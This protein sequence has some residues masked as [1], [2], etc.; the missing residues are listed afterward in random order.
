M[1]KKKVVLTFPYKLI[2]Q[3]I[4]YHLIKDYDLKVNIL[5][6]RINPREEGRLMIEIGGE[7]KS[8]EKGMNYLKEL[9]VEVQSLAQDIR[10]LDE[11]CTHCTV[12]IPICPTEAI[13]LDRNQMIVSFDK[14]KCIGCGLCVPACPYKAVEIL[15]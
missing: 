3:P 1:Q 12:C 2:N 7:E 9:G 5:R 8:L 10:W 13:I 14:D 6:A 11:K 15:F 4:T